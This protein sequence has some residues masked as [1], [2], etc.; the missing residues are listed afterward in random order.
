VEWLETKPTG[1]WTGLA[2]EKRGGAHRKASL[3]WRGST[4]GK[5]RQQARV[6]VT[7]GVRAVGEDVLG[8]V[9][10]GVGSR[11][12]EEGWSRLSA[13]AHVDRSGTAAVVRTRGHRRRLVGHRGLGHRCGARGGVGEFKG[14]PGWCFTG[15]Q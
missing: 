15:A 9:V 10:L 13:V 1:C 8:G 2:A 11:R 4:T 5:R 12:S 3:R 7:G 14:G 6:G